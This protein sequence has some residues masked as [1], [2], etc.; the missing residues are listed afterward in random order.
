[1]SD[2]IKHQDCKI[3]VTHGIADDGHMLFHVNVDG[4]MPYVYTLGLLEAAKENIREMYR[5]DPE[6]A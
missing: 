6:D 1:M 5:G 2:L 3:T 4:D